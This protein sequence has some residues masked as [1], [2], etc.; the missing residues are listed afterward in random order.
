MKNLKYFLLTIGLIISGLYQLSGQGCDPQITGVNIIDR[1]SYCITNGGDDVELEIAWTMGQNSPGCNA[2]AGSWQIVISMPQTKEYKINNPATDILPLAPFTW[3]YDVANNTIR[4]LN[5]AIIAGTSSGIVK[6]NISGTNTANLNTACVDISSGVNI[7][8]LPAGSPFFG[9]PDSFTNEIGNDVSSFYLET[10]VPMTVTQGTISSCYDTQALAEAAAI[11]AT[12]ATTTCSGTVSKTASTSG[13]C[14]AVITVTVTNECGDVQT[15]V[16]NT[17]I[18]NVVPVFDVIPVL[19][20]TTPSRPANTGFCTYTVVG[21]EFDAIASDNCGGITY[22]YVLTGMTTGTG[23]SLAGVTL[24]AGVTTVTWTATDFCG[25]FSTCQFTVTVND[26]EAPM[27]TCPVATTIDKLEDSG[28]HNTGFATAS[29]NCGYAITFSDVTNMLTSCNATGTIPRTWTVTDLS[30]NTASCVQTIT[31]VDQ[32][33]PVISGCPGNISVNN[34]LGECGA[35]VSWVDPT[36]KDKSYFQGFEHPNWAAS[37]GVDWTVGAGSLVR[38]PSL[39]NLIP[40]KTGNAH[41]ILSSPV[42]L[43]GNGNFT[44]LGGYQGGPFVKFRTAV[45][46]YI[47]LNNPLIQNATPTTGYGWDLSSSASNNT[48]GF[49]RDFIFHTAAYDNTGVWVMADNN[50]NNSRRNN[51]LTVTNKVKLVSTGWYTFEWVYRNNGG[52]LAVDCIVRDQFGMLIFSETRQD[53]GDLIGGAGG[54]RYMWFTYFSGGDLPIDNTLVEYDVP[55]ICSP[56]NGSFFN[57]G[58]TLVTCTATDKCTNTSVCSFTVTVTDTEKPVILGCPSNI[59]Q[60]NDLGNCSAVVTWTEPTATDNC[61]LPGSLVWTK[62]H[63]PGSTFPVGTTTVTYTATDAVNNTSLVCSFTVTVTDTEKPV[64]LGCPSNITQVNDLGN[65]SAVVTWT[66]PTA[67]DNCTLPGSLVWTKSHIPG[68]TFPVGTTTVTYTATD[69]FN[70]TSLVCSFTVTVTDTEKPVILGCPSNITQVNDLGNCSA[71]A[72]WTEPTGTDNCTL[73]GSL[74]WTKSH[75]PGSTFPVGTTTVTYTATDAVNNTSLVC[76]FTVTVTDTEKPVILG[77]PSNITQVNDLGN[78]SAV[79]TWTEPTAT[80]NCT[81]PGSLVWTKSHIPGS[82][83]PVGTTTVTYTATDAVNNTSLVCSFTVTVTDTE[84]PVILGC[85]S[86]ITQVNDLGNCSAVVTWTEPTATDNCTLPG[87]LVWTKSHIPGSTF[88]VGTTTV[89]YTATDAV[90]N[91]SLVCSFT[92]TVTDTEKPVILGCPSNITQVNDLGN[93]SAVVTWTEP[94]AT[95]NCTLPGSL[96]WTKSHIPGSSFPVG[97]TTVTYTATDAV[98]NTSLVCSFTVTVNDTQIPTVSSIPVSGASIVGYTC[99]QMLTFNTDPNSCVSS[100][101]IVK[102]I[103]ADNCGVMSSTAAANNGV[104][105]SDFGTFVSGTFPKG[106]TTVTFTGTDNSGNT[107]TCTL[108]IEVKD[109]TPPSIVNCPSNVAVMAPANACTAVVTWTPPPTAFDNCS[110]VTLVQTSSPTTGLGIGSA[111][112]IGVTTILYTATDAAG[113][114]ATCSFTVTVSGTCSNQTELTI[115]FLI[116]ASN[117]LP[118]QNRDA[119]YTVNNISANPTNTP[120]QVFIQYPANLIFNSSVYA[121]ST[122]INMFGFMFMSNNSEWIFTPVMGGVLCTLNGSIPA[123]GTKIIALNIE[124]VSGAI[125]NATASTTGTI[126]TGSGGDQIVGNN[127]AQST[128]TV[129]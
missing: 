2:P 50:T 120:V 67:T 124:A 57:V 92:V 21:T 114:T 115:T 25:K 95:D 43:G 126:G 56:M 45:D 61:T 85:P 62:S 90:N 76:S 35:D 36:A 10:R 24:N 51:I 1:P 55:V 128:F 20:G 46:I 68:S 7:Q 116:E 96:V 30:N 32:V 87:S 86:N 108:I 70:N 81:L 23:S 98:N 15:K 19:C 89:T 6:I 101:T 121:M 16:Y 31:V 118:S 83:F 104:T 49:L 105:I 111:F 93:C 58:P 113:N 41:A 29:D 102:P 5:N 80:D 12:T 28:P 71:V 73:P 82:T 39:T 88:P 34:D 33:D 109:V 66:E 123:G 52:I 13:V 17:R 91:T 64:I 59:T 40:S 14:A 119:I 122:N 79:V 77:C 75:I 103:W 99:G 97:T 38:V 48:T 84:K 18:D 78:C 8:I 100:K 94:T 37:G 63:I 129:N 27:I 4:G 107:N 42:A 54:N 117:F 74:V 69:A 53:P 22:G 26:M 47:D 44:R 72:T 106:I 60:V 9:S 127:Y 112:P 125:K 11:A 3:T 110:G 65:C